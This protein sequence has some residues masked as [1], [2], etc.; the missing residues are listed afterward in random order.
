[1]NVV[2]KSDLCEILDLDGG[3][4]MRMYC[5][6]ISQSREDHLLDTLGVKY[7]IQSRTNGQFDGTLILDFD[8]E[9]YKSVLSYFGEQNGR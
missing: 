5:E 3:N 4:N 8:K 1:M 2:W 6:G 9:D 7:I